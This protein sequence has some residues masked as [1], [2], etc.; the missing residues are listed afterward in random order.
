MAYQSYRLFVMMTD[1]SFQSVPGFIEYVFSWAFPLCVTG[2]FA[3]VGFTYPTHSALPKSYYRV[4]S[5]YLIKR[6]YKVLGVSIFR[7]FLMI[8][9]WGKSKNRK[10][11]F[12]GKRD[13]IEGMMYETK[14]A[15]FGHLGAFAVVL[16]FSIPIGLNAGM[17]SFAII[18]FFNVLGNFYPV[19]LQRHHRIRLQ[20]IMRD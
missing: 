10:N 17:T 16:V 11:F 4:K 14:Q 12:S 7:K 18:S 8:F 2:I 20:R 5:P 6:V 3:F 1:E 19:V 9:F 13:G 15:E